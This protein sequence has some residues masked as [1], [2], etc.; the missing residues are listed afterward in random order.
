MTETRKWSWAEFWIGWINKQFLVWVVS[1]VLVFTGLFVF[2]GSLTEKIKQSLIIIWGIISF[3]LFFYKALTIFIENGKLNVEVK[4]LMD[5]L[6][7]KEG[8]V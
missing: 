8:K 7:S 1:T 4:A 6:K 3:C 5:L 2:N